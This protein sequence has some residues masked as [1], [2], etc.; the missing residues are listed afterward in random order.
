MVRC[1]NNNIIVNNYREMKLGNIF[2]STGG[3]HAGNV[4]DKNYLAP[5]LN[6]C[7]GGYR[8]PII[9]EYIINKQIN[10]HNSRRMDVNDE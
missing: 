9:I 3:N 4:Y 8:E 2:G 5:S 6:T 10:K 1:M 7:Q